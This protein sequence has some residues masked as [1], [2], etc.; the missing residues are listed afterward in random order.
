MA[1]FAKFT[2]LRR[3][4]KA[5]EDAAAPKP[6]HFEYP[7]GLCLCLGDEEIKKLDLD[8]DDCELDSTIHLCCMAKV[9]SVSKR[10][11]GQ[12]GTR[13]ELQVTDIAC[14]DE[15]D[16]NEDM[17]EAKAAKRYAKAEEAGED[18]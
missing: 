9:T 8:V 2:S 17:G 5:P 7:P 1:H 6:F 15:D 11:E 3:D 14:E 13:I 12:G 4:E 10:P 18:E 16:E